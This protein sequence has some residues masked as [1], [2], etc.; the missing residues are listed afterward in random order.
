MRSS[1]RSFSLDCSG[2]G[3]VEHYVLL[4]VFL[5]R[6][7]GVPSIQFREVPV[8]CRG[9]DSVLLGKSRHEGPGTLAEY[10]GRAQA[11]GLAWG[12]SKPWRDSGKCL[13]VGESLSVCTD[14]R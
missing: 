4:V 11:Q 1:A 13:L 6:S 12:I 7:G 10:V 9:V 14:R 2:C 8:N 5:D 3:V